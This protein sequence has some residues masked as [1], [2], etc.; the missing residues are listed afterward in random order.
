VTTKK[1]LTSRELRNLEPGER[2]VIEER[3]CTVKGRNGHMLSVLFDGD[4]SPTERDLEE[5]SVWCMA[6]S[7]L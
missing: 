2:L 3:L 7:A 1:H 5:L 6:K 4:L